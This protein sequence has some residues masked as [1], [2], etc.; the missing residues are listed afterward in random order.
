M[1]QGEEKTVDTY[2]SLRR[3]MIFLFVCLLTTIVAIPWADTQEP[4]K[5]AVIR[6]YAP[7]RSDTIGRLLQSVDDQ[8]R[9]G[10][11]RIILL[12]SS[13]GG[14]VFAGITAYNYLKGIPIEGRYTQFRECRFNRNGALLRRKYTLLGSAS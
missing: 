12:I 6:F 7:V 9:T 13:P 8:V 10:V 3:R 1:A 2:R 4:V 11:K 5:T 14:E